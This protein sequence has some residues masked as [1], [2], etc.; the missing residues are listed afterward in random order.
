MPIRTSARLLGG[1]ALPG[2][3]AG[4]W[5]PLAI[6]DHCPQHQPERISTLNLADLDW[7]KMCWPRAS[8][9]RA[10]APSSRHGLSRSLTHNKADS[11]EPP[12][13]A[14]LENSTRSPQGGSR[15][16]TG[17][18]AQI[19]ARHL[20]LPRAP[21]HLGS[22]LALGNTTVWWA[23]GGRG[24]RAGLL[25]SRPRGGGAGKELTEQ[26]ARR[27]GAQP[28]E[29][30]SPGFESCLLVLTCWTSRQWLGS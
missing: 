12:M 19:K 11:Q 24:G 17:R 10:R 13:R 16:H 21:R 2:F 26:Q 14:H 5:L 1:D 23:R 22:E 9:D 6:H 28:S 4:P 18:N 20:L 8:Q 25:A 30:L 7:T 15:Q 3:A 27:P 29:S